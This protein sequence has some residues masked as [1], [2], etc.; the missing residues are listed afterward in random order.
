MVGDCNSLN[1]VGPHILIGSGT[2]KRYGFIGMGVALFFQQC[3]CVG[4]FWGFL[5]FW[6]GE[7]RVY[8][9]LGYSQSLQEAKAGTQGR[10]WRQELKM[11]LG[12]VLLT[13]LFSMDCLVAFLIQPKTTCPEIVPP[14]VGWAHPHQSLIKKM[15]QW[16][17]YQPIWWRQFLI[18][19]SL[20]P[21]DSSWCHV[22]KN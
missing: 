19:G 18:R 22:D 10:I 17:V 20:F 11:R 12:W 7:E 5:F 14:T 21:S 3:H 9:F 8:W 1:A 15:L 4:R 6:G 16:Y 2:I 13:G